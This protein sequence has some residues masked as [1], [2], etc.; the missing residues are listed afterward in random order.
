MLRRCGPSVTTALAMS[1]RPVITS[2]DRRDMTTPACPSSLNASGAA[3]SCASTTHLLGKPIKY[4]HCLAK[5]A[6]RQ[7]A[8][9]PA[10]PGSAMDASIFEQPPGLP[11]G[12]RQRVGFFCPDQRRSAVLGIDLETLIAGPES[13][14][15]RSSESRYQRLQ[16]WLRRFGNVCPEPSLRLAQPSALPLDLAPGSFGYFCPCVSWYRTRAS[17]LAEK[18]QGCTCPSISARRLVFDWCC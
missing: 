16:Q 15:G 7:I 5:F 14:N 12:C 13:S 11:L 17:L 10:G 3:A 18:S 8:K 9:V 1:A 2:L 4:P 6:A